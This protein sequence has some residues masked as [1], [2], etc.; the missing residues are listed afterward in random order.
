[1]C[2]DAPELDCDGGVETGLLTFDLLVSLVVPFDWIVVGETPDS[3]TVN[4]IPTPPA[5]AVH[6]GR[7]RSRDPAGNTSDQ[8]EEG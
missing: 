4:W 7:V 2:W 5:G 1:M 6:F 8:C 3:C